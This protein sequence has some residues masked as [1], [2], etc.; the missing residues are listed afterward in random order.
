[1]GYYGKIE[2]KRLAQKLRKQG[3]SYTEIK[4]KVPVSKNTL[5][6][7]CRDIPLSSLQE[8]RLLEKKVLG[9]RRGSLVAANNKRIRRIQAWEITIKETKKELGAPS[10]RDRF[11]AGLA[12]YAGEGYKTNGQCGLA[13]A[14]PSIILFMKDWFIEFCETPL[15]KFRGAVWIHANQD[16]EAAVAFWSQLTQI[17]PSQFHKTYIVQ[18]NS[19]TKKV[20]K[21][22][23]THGIFSL[24][25]CDTKS[26]HRILG[27]TKALFGGTVNV[28]TDPR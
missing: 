10:K 13:N 25:F 12:L 27:W 20:R 6:R 7:W 9:Q 28:V 14:D 21:N 2:E 5:S 16:A 22:I 24:R 15:E 18:N 23:H 26:Y 4:Q 11:I 19:D 1:M 3:Y 8:K 17:P